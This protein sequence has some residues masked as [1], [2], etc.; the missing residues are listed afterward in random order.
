MKL[1][2]NKHNLSEAE[3]VN[4]TGRVPREMEFLEFE[5]NKESFVLSRR[6]EFKRRIT[7]AFKQMSDIEK[8]DFLT[9][10]DALFGLQAYGARIR[11]NGSAVDTGLFYRDG[12]RYKCLSN[13]A[14]EMLM[15]L[16]LQNVQ[17]DPVTSKVYTQQSNS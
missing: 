15:E 4:L 8:H 2:Q 7:N 6:A 12:L 1:F 13:I 9:N 10:L 14:S 3:L 5:E 17:M 11:F 16:F